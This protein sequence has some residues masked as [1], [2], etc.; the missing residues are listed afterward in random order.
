M[1]V[2]SDLTA[3]ISLVFSNLSLLYR[4][5]ADLANVV[6]PLPGRKWVP[7]GASHDDGHVSRRG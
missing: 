2:R 6:L 4:A 7:G 1:A 5:N 3:K